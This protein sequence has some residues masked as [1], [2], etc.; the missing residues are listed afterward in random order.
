MSYIAL[1]SSVAP[2]FINCVANYNIANNSKIDVE[3]ATPNAV[4]LIAGVTEMERRILEPLMEKF[5]ASIVE[6]LP[7]RIVF[8]DPK[9]RLRRQADEYAFTRR[10]ERD[11][12][13][14]IPRRQREALLNSVV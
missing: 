14:D 10:G 8:F 11:R 7:P 1:A 9:P 12:S 13:L 5:G 6:E 3:Y 4:K 2:M